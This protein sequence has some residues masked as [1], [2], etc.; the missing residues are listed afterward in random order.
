MKQLKLFD[1]GHVH[2]IRNPGGDTRITLHSPAAV[3]FTDFNTHTPVVIDASASAVEVEGLMQRA[4]VKL[5]LVLDNQ[6]HF[7][8]VISLADLGEERMIREVARGS[9]R[10]EVLVRDLMQP[11][12]RLRALG[13]EEVRNAMVQD[14]LN[15]LRE[16][17]AQHALVLDEASDEICGLISA[18]DLARKLHVP[19]RPGA[20]AVFSELHNALTRAP[21]VRFG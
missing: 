7:S 6:E 10:S 14:V 20:I 8:G 3:V 11:R 1:V 15:A 16:V 4:H 5:M 2:S 19:L 12:S 9:Q 13:L 18:S 21:E 17:R